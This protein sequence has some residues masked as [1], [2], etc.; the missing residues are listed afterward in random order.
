MPVD[1]FE[2][3]MRRHERQVLG[4]ALRLLGHR[5]DAQDVAQEVFL[6]RHRHLG[7]VE[8]GTDPGAWLYRVTV[9]WSGLRK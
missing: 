4:V 5:E 7:R 2:I 9:N 8:K 6:R 3:L 1:A